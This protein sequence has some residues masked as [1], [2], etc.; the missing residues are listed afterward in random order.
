MVRMKAE[1]QKEFE[2]ATLRA[3][4]A[5]QERV[6]KEQAEATAVLLLI[7]QQ[8]IVKDF[9]PEFLGYLS[10]KNLQSY[11]KLALPMAT[12]IY[13]SY[14]N[15]NGT[16]KNLQFKYD[17]FEYVDFSEEDGSPVKSFRK[18]NFSTDFTWNQMIEAAMSQYDH[19][20]TI[21]ANHLKRQQKEA[22]QS[23]SQPPKL[24]D[25]KSK[26]P[27]HYFHTLKHQANLNE[28]FLSEFETNVTY[29]LL[30]IAEAIHRLADRTEAN[31]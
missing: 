21:L 24:E 7:K 9:P 29:G 2:A 26:I 16:P 13:I 11:V 6:A 28:Q 19:S 22:L 20:E 8:L 3:E 5:E 15:I 4:Q 31:G 12:T 14:E 23:E 27:A 17:T 1:A 25:Q 30:A 18:S 10:L